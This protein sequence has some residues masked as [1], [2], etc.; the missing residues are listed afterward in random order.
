LV[1]RFARAGISKLGG[2][3]LDRPLSGQRALRHEI[4]SRFGLAPR[5]GV[6]VGLTI[7]ALRAGYRVLEVPMEVEHA[8]TTRD[9]S[10]FAHRAEQGVDI[11]RALGHR[12]LRR[13]KLDP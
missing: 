13:S 4:V 10:G 9:L 8:R 1:E 7:D 6:E 12:G 11:L 3:S 5:F 2:V